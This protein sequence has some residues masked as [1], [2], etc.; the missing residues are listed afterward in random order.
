MALFTK[1]ER[2]EIYDA[3][4]RSD[5]DPVECNL[6]VS[7]TIAVL[8]HNSGSRLEFRVNTNGTKFRVHSVIPDVSDKR[9]EI[10]LGI[11]W[12][13][14]YVTDWANSVKE[15]VELIDLWADMRRGQEI[16]SDMQSVDSGNTSFTQDE[17]RQ[18]SAQ[19]REIKEQLKERFEL[20]GEQL[21]K[22][23]ER[24]DEAEEASKRM[25][26]KDWF[27]Y[28]LGTISALTIA[29][30]VVPGVGEHIFTMFIHALG[31][32]FTDGSEPPQI[33]T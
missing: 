30:T 33:L 4:A 29:T 24:L 7:Q 23:N 19:L 9:D 21:E 16:L 31:H 1:P 26:R 12:V 8:T 2:N 28:F 17:Q 11:T 5:L 14:P 10:G 6:E 32:L 25:G 27:I 18:I 3:I 15:G 22:I 13:A 20:T